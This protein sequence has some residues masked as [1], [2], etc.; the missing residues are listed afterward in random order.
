[1]TKYLLNKFHSNKCTAAE[2]DEFYTWI[3]GEQADI[4]LFRSYWDEIDIEDNPDLERSQAR[5]N[6]VHHTI[7]LNQSKRTGDKKHDLF[8]KRT[9][10]VRLFSK[11]AAVLILPVLT[12]YIYIQFF[13]SD[14]FDYLGDSSLYEVVAPP[15]SRTQFELSDGTVV[16]LNQGSK[17]TYPHHFSGST[18]TVQ[19]D[20][21]AYFDVAKNKEIP[22]IVESGNL[23]VKAV[24]TSFNVKA[25][26][27]DVKFETSLESGK[28]IIL[29]GPK[30]N[31]VEVCEMEPGERFVFDE[32]TKKYSLKQED[33]T[34]YV[35]WKEGK[36]IFR[37][38]PLNEVVDRLSRWYNVEIQLED[39]GLEYLTITAT[40][41]DEPLEQVLEM[42]ESIAPISYTVY[43]RSKKSDGTFTEKKILIGK[44]GGNNIN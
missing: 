22:F 25:F 17:L 23:A 14:R 29:N 26:K 43:G 24:G 7:N 38:N 20:G 31:T 37:E 41:V 9:R 18:R 11:V 35:S 42:M 10:I 27:D 39:P 28:V 36:L 33:L 44:K 3:S 6:K 8:G 13:Q 16:W 34:A 5:L 32:N 21:E 2:V 30:D 40:F 4:N 15:N 1:M 19:L 12:L